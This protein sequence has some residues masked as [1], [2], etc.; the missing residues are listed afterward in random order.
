MALPNL[1]QLEQHAAAQPGRLKAA[2]YPAGGSAL[3]RRNS[4]AVK[5]AKTTSRAVPDGLRVVK[6]GVF[7]V[8]LKK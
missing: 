2:R 6:V 1:V 8:Y 7:S 3:K 4:M 5:K